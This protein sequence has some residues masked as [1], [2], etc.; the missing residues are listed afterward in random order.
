MV[1][2][3]IFN[4]LT[5]MGLLFFDVSPCVSQVPWGA[6]EVWRRSRCSG[7]LGASVSLPPFRWSVGFP[8]GCQVLVFLPFPFHCLPGWARC[9]CVCCVGVLLFLSSFCVPPPRVPVKYLSFHF[10]LHLI[11]IF[12]FI[13]IFISFAGTLVLPRCGGACVCVTSEE[14]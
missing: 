4:Q 9:V 11:F 1:G 3:C 10:H 13:L 14:M 7:W 6:A 5:P 12:F 8:F 2:E